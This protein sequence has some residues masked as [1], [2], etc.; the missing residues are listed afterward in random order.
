MIR[1][2]Y[3]QAQC[4]H[5][6]ERLM[7]GAIEFFITGAQLQHRVLPLVMLAGLRRMRAFVR[8]VEMP[9]AIDQVVDQAAVPGR[10]RIEADFEAEPPIRITR[11]WAV[12]MRADMHATNKV[13]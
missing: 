7:I 12:I 5:V 2:D 1:A 4:R 10:T 8:T 6:L 3:R 9:G 11:A 13:L